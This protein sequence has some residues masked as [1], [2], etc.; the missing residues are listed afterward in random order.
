MTQQTKLS[1]GLCHSFCFLLIP[2]LRQN[3][4]LFNSQMPS[5]LNSWIKAFLHE[6]VSNM[7]KGRCVF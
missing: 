1:Y 3:E 4:A 6:V 2:K 7:I 5:K